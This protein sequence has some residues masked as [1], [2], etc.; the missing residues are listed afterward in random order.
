VLQLERRGY[1]DI[2]KKAMALAVLLSLVIFSV[3]I[4]IKPEIASAASTFYISTTG[5]DDAGHGGSTGAGAWAT[6]D[7]ALTGNRVSKGDTIKIQSGTYSSFYGADVRIRPSINTA[8]GSGPVIIETASGSKD[9]TMVLPAN[10]S[11]G[12]AYLFLNPD[13]WT[14]LTFRN[15]SFNNSNLANTTFLWEYGH[16]VVFEDCNINMNDTGKYPVKIGNDTESTNISFIRSVVHNTPVGYLV[17]SND[18]TDNADVNMLSESSLFYDNGSSV[19][20]AQ[21][22]TNVTVLNS[23]INLSKTSAYLLFLRDSGSHITVKNNI[24]FSSSG[25]HLLVNYFIA[26]NT[27]YLYAIDNP[28]TWD[29]TNNIWYRSDGSYLPLNY[30]ANGGSLLRVDSTNHS[31]DP[32]F[33]NYATGDYSIKSDTHICGLGTVGSLPAGGDI[34][35][36]YW[37]GADVGAYKCPSTST[38]VVLGDKVAFVGDSIMLADGYDQSAYKY[39]NEQTGIDYSTPSAAAQIGAGMQKIFSKI[40]SM[41][42]T[43]PPN[44]VFLSVGINDLAGENIVTDTNQYIDYLPELMKK[45]ENWGATPIWLGIGSLRNFVRLGVPLDDTTVDALNS[46]MATV[47][48]ANNWRYGNYLDQMKL[49]SNWQTDYYWADGNVHPNDAGQ[50]IIG[51]T[52]EYLYYPTKKTIGTDKFDPSGTVRVYADGQY[53]YKS[54]GTGSQNAD[55]TIT[56][57]SGFVANSDAPLL[58][59]AFTTWDR[60]G[61]RYKKWTESSTY[62]DLTNTQHTV[63]NLKANTYYRVLVDD[64]FGSHI[65]GDDCSDGLCKSI[66]SGRIT[67]TYGGTYSSHTFVV[68]EDATAPNIF[69]P[70]VTYDDNSATM[71]WTTDEQSS[72]QVQY[73]FA[74]NYVSS[75]DE[76]DTSPMVTSHTVSISDLAKCTQ[77]HYRVLSKD[78]AGNERTSGDNTFTTT[79]C[80][81][82]G[83]STDSTSSSQANN[84]SH[85]RSSSVDTATKS[86]FPTNAVAGVSVTLDASDLFPGLDAVKYMWDLG[87]SSTDEGKIINHTYVNPGRYNITITAFDIDGNKETVAKTIDVNPAPP[88]ITSVKAIND[89]DILLEGTGYN[90]DTI[91]LTIESTAK[92]AQTTVD[93]SGKWTYTLAQASEVIGEGDHTVSAVDSYRLADN[94]ELKSEASEAVKF[95]VTVDDGKLKVEMEKSNRWRM[96]AYAL[97]GVIILIGSILIF[98]KRRV[99]SQEPI[100]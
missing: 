18:R 8:S 28:A 44:T 24:I 33:T 73:G 13:S 19:F 88:T 57:E 20:K 38:G 66:A 49:D 76:T 74:S 96:F 91:E 26:G 62:P 48:V 9:V 11:A 99:R 70:S 69:G 45:I 7:Y 40:D 16:S 64:V 80:S 29:V 84:S 79:G 27:A 98:R 93:G 23:T 52:A 39:F 56:P 32:S 77:Y 34:N 37:T 12:S 4:V 10:T 86:P 58:D 94:T 78:V 75:S 1:L 47:C 15:I 46:G 35:K 87:D 59:L 14:E 25:T 30:N 71:A 82:Q 2:C 51:E 85:F 21:Y 61:N 97:G 92:E 36:Q 89:T 53:R 31:L 90:N 22:R 63:G 60:T 5:T 41:M 55:L 3:H 68:E 81:S 50:Q 67:F 54:G 83:D 43:D 42:V 6:L 100:D 95:K 72:S 65:V 17:V